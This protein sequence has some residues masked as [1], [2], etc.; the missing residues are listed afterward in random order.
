MELIR[1]FPPASLFSEGCVLT[2]GNFD[3]LHQGHLTLIDRVS[4]ISSE[5]GLP[6]VLLTF[7]PKPWEFFSGK[8]NSFRLMRPREFLSG[9]EIKNIH[10]AMIFRFNHNLASYTADQFIQCILHEMINVKHLVVG[11]DFHFG[12]NRS[13]DLNYLKARETKYRYKVECIPSK[14]MDMKKISSTWVRELLIK[15]KLDVVKALLGRPYAVT[16]KVIKGRQVGRSLGFPTANIIYFGK[17]VPLSGVYQVVI[18]IGNKLYNGIANI[19][20]RP[21]FDNEIRKIL[22]VHVFE[23]NQDLY[24]RYIEVNFINKI[25]E[26]KKF[27][28]IESLK[29]Q[30]ECDV[31]M[32]MRNK[33][34][35]SGYNF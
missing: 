8:S 21:T 35:I 23:F 32:L 10:Y 28:G 22:E 30:I 18:K 9:L 13:G 6:A 34:K 4:E 1:G 16:G 11:E 14:R 31:A 7:E 24:G 17:Q 3:G 20:N 5:T 25:R 26:E 19:G 2:I 27:D 29:S 15:N 12:K 33:D